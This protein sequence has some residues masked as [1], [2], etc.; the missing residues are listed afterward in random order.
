MHRSSNQVNRLQQKTTSNE[1]P[2]TNK[3]LESLRSALFNHKT[4][5]RYLSTRILFKI[6]AGRYI[7]LG[8]CVTKQETLGIEMEA[9]GY[10]K[11]LKVWQVKKM[12]AKLREAGLITYERSTKNRASVYS[13]TVTELGLQCFDYFIR[14]N[15]QKLSTVSVNKKHWVKKVPVEN[16]K[17][18]HLETK[19]ITPRA[20]SQ[21]IDKYDNAKKNHTSNRYYINNIGA[22]PVSSFNHKIKSSPICGTVATPRLAPNH[23]EAVHSFCKLHGMDKD[24]TL[25]LLDDTAVALTESLSHGRPVNDFDGFL[26]NVADRAAQRYYW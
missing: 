24:K 7:K 13:Y 17:K 18:S 3:E 23:I 12:C 6:I 2:Q 4:S 26:V 20:V 19:K 8:N 21:P 25:I 11:Q 10:G 1:R 15:V 14:R 9:F 5:G 22:A 16:G